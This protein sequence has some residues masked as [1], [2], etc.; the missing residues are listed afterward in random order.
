M[1]TVI[2]ARFSS[3]L[4]NSRSIDDQVAVCRERCEAEGWTIVDVFRDYAIGGGAGVDENQRP[5]LFSM[6]ELVERG[7]IDQVLADTSSRIARNQGDAHHLRDR[8]NF[9]GARIFTLA[10]GEINALTGGIKGLLDEQMRKDLGHNIRRA[11]RGRA[12]QGLSPAGIAYGYR[13]IL[14]FDDRGRAINGLREFD[15]DTAPI[16]TRIFTEYASGRS[17]RQICEDLNKDGIAPPSGQFWQ[18]NTL[19]G[20][21]TRQD[22]I[23]R[24]WLYNGQLVVGRTQKLIDPRT[25]KTRIRPRPREEWSFNPVPHLQIIDDDLWQAVELQFAKFAD[26]P[27]EHA[28][29]PAKLLSKLCVCGECG[30]SYTIVR[31]TRWG[32]RGF[33]QGGPSVCTNSRTID[34]DDLERR[35]INGLTEQLLDPDMVSA[36]VREYHLDYT[37]RAGEITGREAAIRAELSECEARIG[38]LVAAIAD[39][40]GAFAEIRQALSGATAERDAL[41]G[42]LA[43][44]DTLP[45]VALHPQI[46]ERYRAMVRDLATAMD[47]PEA[48]KVAAPELRALIDTILITPAKAEKGVDIQIVGRL[49]NMIAMATGAP[50]NTAAPSGTLTMERV[51]GIEPA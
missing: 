22:G 25:R 42:E 51:A 8:I 18:V 7:G 41:Q 39:G 36:F 32:C 24:N 23:L 3:N 10:D 1:R 43:D 2:Y 31:K 40:G 38:R 27:R 47:N 28:R 12:S 50:M 14:Q 6:L 4:Q 9:A 45:V 16:V 29:R 21:R 44:L 15:P 17:A 33:R 19:A 11:Q 26:R 13:K 37:R 35:A 34:N 20:S 46:A 5:G 30:N 48:L 49:A